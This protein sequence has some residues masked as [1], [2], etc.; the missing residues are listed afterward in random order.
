MNTFMWLVQQ[1]GPVKML[2]WQ[3]A[4]FDIAQWETVRTNITG[5]DPSSLSILIPFSFLSL[6]LSFSQAIVVLLQVRKPWISLPFV[7]LLC[8]KKKRRKMKESTIKCFNLNFELFFWATEKSR[9]SLPNWDCYRL[10]HGTRYVEFE[11]FLFYFIFS[12]TEQKLGLWV[13]SQLGES[14]SSD[15]GIACAFALPI[16]GNSNY[17][18]KITRNCWTFIFSLSLVFWASRQ[19]ARVVSSFYSCF[20]P[21]QYGKLYSNSGGVWNLCLIRSLI[22]VWIVKVEL[23]P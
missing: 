20:S 3:P 13:L 15:C 18:W 17:Y 19:K 23:S 10:Q 14:L 8:K 21:L 1:V 5:G 9:R 16:T 7:W 12:S 11:S 2:T 22:W 6:Y 4:T